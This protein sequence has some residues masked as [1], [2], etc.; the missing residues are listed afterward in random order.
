MKNEAMFPCKRIGNAKL[1]HSLALKQL[2]VLQQFWEAGFN[3][4]FPP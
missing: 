3:L 2:C 4:E 1:S